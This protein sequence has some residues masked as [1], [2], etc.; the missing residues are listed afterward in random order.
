MGFESL[1]RLVYAMTAG[2]A[3]CLQGVAAA[4]ATEPKAQVQ[5]DLPADL[6]AAVV[7]AV[8][9][10]DKPIENRFEARRRA[11]DAA[12]DAITVLRS[13]G[14]YAYDVE[15]DLGD[16]DTPKPLV[17]IAPGPRFHLGQ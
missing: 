6:R 1:A 9:D 14:Y 8:G 11:R 17:K 15:P 16:G 12:E 3:L 4:A 5:G 13:E 2:A 7:H 10:T